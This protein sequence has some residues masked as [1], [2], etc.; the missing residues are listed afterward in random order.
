MG[1]IQAQ[2][3]KSGPENMPLDDATNTMSFVIPEVRVVAFH[4]NP[5]K[6]VKSNFDIH[7]LI[8]E[9]DSKYDEYYVYFRS[10]K[11]RMVVNYD[12][13]GKAIS[14][15]QKFKDVILP[16]ETSLSIYRDYKGW[17][18]VGNK[19]IAVSRKGEVKKEFYKV[20]LRND[21]KRKIL[22]IEVDNNESMLELA[23]K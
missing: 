15:K 23:L 12:K 16:R 3:T 9:N 13:K 11:G 4:S 19:Y 14:T 10:P 18:I 6:Y 5:L 2:K 21:K 7:R 22:K 1:N 17:D 8:E 20:K